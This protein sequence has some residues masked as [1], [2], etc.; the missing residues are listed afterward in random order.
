MFPVSPDAPIRG[1]AT[2]SGAGG[3]E[4]AEEEDEVIELE[5]AGAVRPAKSPLAPTRAEREAHEATHLPFRSWCAACV[6]GRRDNPPHSKM[7]EEEHFVPEVLM[8][9]AFVRRGDEKETITILVVKDRGTRAIRAAVLR[10]KGIA[11]DESAECAVDFIKG[12]GYKGRVLLKT[13]N[14]PALISLRAEVARRLEENAAAPIAPPAHEHQSN[15][16]VENGVK[17]VKVLLR[18]HL[19]ALEG[20]I[21]GHIPSHHP[22]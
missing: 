9:Y 18:V 12:F 3:H 16:A 19:L 11:L 2:G 7:P 13:D 1:E 4:D 8:D 20:K 14:E 22:S 21:G 5:E 10:Q 15:G 17:F 6:A